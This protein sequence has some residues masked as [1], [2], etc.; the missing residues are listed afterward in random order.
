MEIKFKKQR[1]DTKKKEKINF[2]RSN[3][4]KSSTVIA[5]LKK[6]IFR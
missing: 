5:I 3:R 6:I 2:T 4:E 1:A